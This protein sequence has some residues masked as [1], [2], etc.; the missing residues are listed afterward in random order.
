MADVRVILVAPKFEG[1]V[2]AVARSMANF[3]VS[4]LYLVH[5]CKIGD[6]AYR[7][8]KHGANILDNAKI[9]DSIK[10][11]VEG[12]F[13]VVGTSG[14]TTKNDKKYVRIPMSVHEFANKISDYR[15]KIAILFG[16]EDLGLLKSELTECDV[17]VHIPSSETYP[18]LNLSHA[19]AVVLYELFGTTTI[20]SPKSANHEEKERMFR[21][22]DDLLM[23]IN[24]PKHRIKNTSI[25][26]RK[27]MGRAVPSE[28]EYSTIMGVFGDALKSIIENSKQNQKERDE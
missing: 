7:R 6:D 13:L 17:L 11:S 14:I 18:I 26:F 21:Y 20:D 12:C 28:H 27:I 9:V 4:E 5:P 8:A 24:Y 1:N 3:D 16:R 23:N 15:E 25:M 19:V 22:F 10:E 2:G